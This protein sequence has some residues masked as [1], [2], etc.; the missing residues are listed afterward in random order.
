[1]LVTWRRA[2]R[3]WSWGKNEGTVSEVQDSESLLKTVAF[4][5]HSL[6]PTLSC[7]KTLVTHGKQRK[8]L[9]SEP[10]L[11]EFKSKDYYC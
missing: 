3:T 11:P 10:G 1:M 5:L 2:P 6:C 8:M 4:S 9:K 7:L